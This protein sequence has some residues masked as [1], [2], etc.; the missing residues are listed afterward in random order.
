[1]EKVYNYDIQGMTVNFPDKLNNLLKNKIYK[2]IIIEE[3]LI[4]SNCLN[5]MDIINT[6]IAHNGEWTLRKVNLTKEKIEYLSNKIKSPLYYMH[7]WNDRDVV[8]VFKDKTF[9]INYDNKDT[10]KDAID[11]GI[12]IG[13]P[14]EQLDFPIE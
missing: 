12:S 4:D 14:K 6:R 11:Y 3:S 2:G 1:M 10:W 8:V 5:E 9:E 13:I 7:F